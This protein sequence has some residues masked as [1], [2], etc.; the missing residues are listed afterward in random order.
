M[1]KCT[2]CK[3]LKDESNFGKNRTRKDGVRYECK[4]CSNRYSRNVKKTIIGKIKNIYGG[5][6][7]HSKSR[8]HDKPSYTKNELVEYLV[9]NE[10]F[11]K[12][13]QEWV[14]S[15]YSRGLAPSIDRLDNNCGYSFDNIRIT[16][17]HENNYKELLKKG[18]YNQNSKPK[19][20]YESNPVRRCNFRSICKRQGWDYND[21]IET[22]SEERY[23]SEKKYYYIYSV[24]GG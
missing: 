7:C 21:F 18:A 9:S 15:D 17:W 8:G 12:L 4:E 23:K 13:Y 6:V 22:D 16:T 11:I 3:I 2:T 20:H 5:Q 24:I 19:E 1:R 10:E 14:E